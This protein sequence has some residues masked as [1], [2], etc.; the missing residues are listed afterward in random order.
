MSGESRNIY[1]TARKAAGLTQEAAAEQLAVSV[2]SLRAYENGYRTGTQFNNG[3]NE[4][5]IGGVLLEMDG[6]RYDNTVRHRLEK[7]HQAMIGEA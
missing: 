7:I 2:E 4:K 1:Q 5:V 3:N 6:K